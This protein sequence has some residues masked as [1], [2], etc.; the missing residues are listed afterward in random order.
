LEHRL[1]ESRKRSKKEKATEVAFRLMRKNSP[2]HAAFF[3]A[4][5]R[6]T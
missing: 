4:N 5:C 6:S 2:D 3:A 1:P